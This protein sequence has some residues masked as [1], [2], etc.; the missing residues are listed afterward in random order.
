MVVEGTTSDRAQAPTTEPALPPRL[1]IMARRVRARTNVCERVGAKTR[2]RY[3]LAADRSPCLGTRY[4]ASSP[5]DW[6]E[7]SVAH[8][9]CALARRLQRQHPGGRK[10]TQGNHYTRGVWLAARA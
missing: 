5:H 9:V 8:E 3:C 10:I 4:A 2:P 6:Q 1:S 7:F